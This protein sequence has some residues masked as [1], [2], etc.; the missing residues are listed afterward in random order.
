MSESKLHDAARLL[1]S[2][3]GK[4]PKTISAAD[5]QRR[6]DWAKGLARIREA[7]RQQPVPVAAPLITSRYV[8]IDRAG[9]RWPYHAETLAHAITLA[10]HDGIDAIG[11]KVEKEQQL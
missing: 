8:V 4:A 7:K 2:R 6:R 3:G 10:R 5:R 11:G 1:G 9:R